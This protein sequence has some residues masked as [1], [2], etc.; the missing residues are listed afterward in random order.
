MR[1]DARM[2]PPSRRERI[3]IASTPVLVRLGRV[4]GWLLAVAVGTCVAVALVVGSRWSALALTPVLA[5]LGWL[6]YLAWPGLSA[7]ARL[8][9][10]VV[11]GALLAWMASVLI[12][13]R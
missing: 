11:L 12:T 13:G 1:E 9:R 7:G 2:P 10:L 3:V 8:L 5:L 4:P 6:S